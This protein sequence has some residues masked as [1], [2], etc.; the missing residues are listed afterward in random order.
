[1]NNKPDIT[2]S[3]LDL[4]RLYNLIESLPHND[5]SGLELLEEELNRANV[6]PPKEM[7][8]AVV[9]MNST[10]RFYVESAGKEFELTLVYPKDMDNSGKK[11]SILAPAGSA[12]IG[13]AVG[14]EIEWPKPTG[15]TLKVKITEVLYQPER[16]GDF[17]S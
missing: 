9:T 7:P 5:A 8:E 1:M 17:V 15:G 2:I 3:T 13:L 11:V 16:A 10:V 12:L 4:D 14:D 6:V